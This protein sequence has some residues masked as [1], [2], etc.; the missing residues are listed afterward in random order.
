MTTSTY[1]LIGFFSFFA[2]HLIGE[3][4][5][6]KKNEEKLKELREL[7]ELGKFIRYI[8]KPLLM[9][10]LAGFYISYNLNLNSDLNLWVI[11]GIAGGFFGDVSLMIPDPDKT[12]GFFK[13][14][15]IS[16]LL[17]HIFYIVALLQMAAG[18]S[19]F[20]WWSLVLTIPYIAIGVIV[21]PKLTKHT[22]KMT[23]PV[24]LYLVVIVLM[25]VC[26]TFLWGC[27]EPIGVIILMI[28]ALL[29]IISDTINAFNKF[30]KEIP[31]ERLYTM[32][33]YLLG[34]FLLILGFL[35]SV[36]LVSQ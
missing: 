26:T 4:L 2:I 14:G 29:F 33:T 13:I 28:G 35:Y 27:C 18:F 24:T 30:A 19:R 17:G 15:L 12:K 7:G 36:P 5:I 25:G 11:L 23:I 10:L 20:Q 32:S 1:F 21:Y 16:F 6:I 31:F 8:S 9:P 34:Q 22:G 3:F